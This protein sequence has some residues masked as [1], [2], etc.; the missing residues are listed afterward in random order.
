MNLARL[1][2][3]V[4][5]Q[6]ARRPA[7][8]ATSSP[9][10]LVY[11]VRF[12]REVMDKGTTRVASLMFDLVD[13]CVDGRQDASLLGPDRGYDE[14][15][16]VW[17]VFVSNR[18]YIHSFLRHVAF[19]PPTR[20]LLFSNVGCAGEPGSEDGAARK[21]WLYNWRT[22]IPTDA[23][24]LAPILTRWAARMQ[25]LEQHTG[26]AAFPF[27]FV[28]GPEG[29][30]QSQASEEAGTGPSAGRAPKP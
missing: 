30:C 21:S 14:A 19:L 29:C 18:L 9:T 12:D 16:A 23:R 22:S 15:A 20:V 26:P 2:R 1:F 10:D 11:I 28:H 5:D 17:H 25:E 3:Y 27:S 6:W 24:S 8:G 13:I 4:E 7:G